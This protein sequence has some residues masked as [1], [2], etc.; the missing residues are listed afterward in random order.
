MIRHMPQSAST[1]SIA[2]CVT[3][4]HPNARA[5]SPRRCVESLGSAILESDRVSI[6]VS[7]TSRPPGTFSTNVLSNVALCASMGMPP[8]KS[9]RRATASVAPGASATS[10]SLM[11]VSSWISFG[12]GRVGLT[13]V[14]KRSVTSRPE[15][16]AA[17]ISI[18]SQSRNER[19]VVSVSS[20]TTSSSST[21]NERVFARSARVRYRSATE[22]GVP[23]SS[24]SRTSE[25][26]I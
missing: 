12:M 4:S 25:A 19:P 17:A 26:S 5:M 20:T 3:E 23:G 21:S 10:S 6:H 14:W 13:K 2:R 16:R 11:F 7:L 1:S 22:S 18:S 15:M 24:R 8:T 9:A